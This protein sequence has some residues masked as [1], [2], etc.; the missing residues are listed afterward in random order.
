MAPETEFETS[1]RE[2]DPVRMGEAPFCPACGRAIGARRWLPPYRAE[3]ETWGEAFGDIVFGPA[4]DILV[5]ER[6]TL[7]WERAGLVGLEGFD[8]VEIV[9][10]VR[11]GR[12]DGDLPQYFHVDVARSEAAIDDSSSTI[13]RDDEPICPDCRL[14]GIIKHV[15]RVVLE[16]SPVPVEDLFVARGLPGTVLASERFRDFCTTQRILNAVL[17][18]ARN[19]CVGP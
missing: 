19:Y 13:V 11:H 17:V 2:A 3:M 1:Y 16:P 6:F 8:P 18:P 5:S 9:K 10:V 12:L 4:M 7:L 14:G 15:C